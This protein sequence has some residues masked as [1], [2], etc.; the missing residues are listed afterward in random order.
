MPKRKTYIMEHP[1]EVIRLELKTDPN[2]LRRQAR[3][4]GL[5]PGL[6][7]LD[8]GCGPGKTTSIFNNMVQPG[9]CTV[10]IDYSRDRINYAK[11]HYGQKE[12]MDFFVR[13][14]MESMKDIGSFDIV[15]VRFI[16]EYFR[17]DSLQLVNNL[18]QCLKPGGWLC[19]VDLDYNC[20]NHYELPAKMEEMLQ[21]MMKYME[22]K[23]N[24][25]P[26]AGR[27]LYSY[28]YDSGFEHIKVHVTAHHLF[29]GRIAEHHLY[30]W[31][32]KLE[33]NA[34]RVNMLFKSYPGGYSS[35]MK[36]FRDFF[37]S[38]RRFTYTPMILCRGRK[39][40][41]D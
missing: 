37:L 2:E 29:Y 36:N 17:K 25:D 4:C 14:F 41:K 3:W 12:G 5:K 19:L 9:G 35:F 22:R 6:R 11:K 7:V 32:K 33:V 23:F 1:D 8:V 39:P 26:Y 38:E 40:L 30:N 34:S 24:F 15:W 31:M 28:L 18:K 16:L 10:G 21:I 20:L 13:D 27:K